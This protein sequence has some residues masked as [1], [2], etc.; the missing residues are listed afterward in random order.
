M[1]FQR[2]SEPMVEFDAHEKM[3][4]ALTSSSLGLPMRYIDMPKMRQP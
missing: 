2:G 1:Y 3:V 4:L